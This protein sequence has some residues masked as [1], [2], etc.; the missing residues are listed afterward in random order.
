MKDRTLAYLLVFPAALLMLVFAVYPFMDSI[1][2]SFFDID[3][4]SNERTFIGMQNFIDVLTDPSITRAFRLSL[5]WTVGNMIIQIVAGV[6]I[7]LVLNWQLKGIAFARGIVLFPYMVPAVVLAM[8]FRYMFND[9]TGLVT[10]LMDSIGL[11]SFGPLADPDVVMY[12]LILVNSWKYT[13]FIV[14]LVLGRLQTV[15]KELYEAA[16]IDGAGT[17]RKFASVTLPWIL[18]VLLVSGLIRTMWVAYDYDVPYLLAFGGPLG[19]S[20]TVPI[21]IR[22]LAFDQ[23]EVGLASAVAVV[24]ALFLVIIAAWFLG[25][26]RRTE[27]DLG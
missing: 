24:M 10:Y 4:M 22:Q 2:N 9:T 11:S 6:G 18:P 8:I 25:R 16:A 17:G 13:P 26:F 5:I 3:P 15:P 23:Q 21:H 20:T 1:V 7:A 27:A 14:I 12:M 19:A